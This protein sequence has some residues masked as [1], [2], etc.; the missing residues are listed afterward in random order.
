MH[1][2]ATLI[3][4]LTVGALYAYLR[5]IRK[6]P[7]QVIYCKSV[8][9]TSQGSVA[10]CR[11][12]EEEFKQ[13]LACLNDA[14]HGTTVNLLLVGEPGVGKTEFMNG[15]AQRLRDREVYKFKNWSLFGAPNAIHSPGEKMEEA[16]RE[17]RGYTHKTI[18]F[19][20]ELGDAKEVGTFLKAR[21]E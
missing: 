21:F 4:G 18:F 12:P 5:W 10:S 20:D 7:K 14:R 6:C 15:L 19:C 1:L 9:Q 17:V 3:I 11:G 8:R 16:F 2:T 13:A